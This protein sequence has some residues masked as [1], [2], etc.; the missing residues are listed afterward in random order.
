MIDEAWVATLIAKYPHVREVYLCGS[1]AGGWARPTSDWDVLLVL[2]DAC[3]D[4]G[5][6]LDKIEQ[7]IAFDPD[8]RFDGLD[9]FFWR[10]PWGELAR[11]EF[12][13]DEDIS[14]RWWV[15]DPVFEPYYRTGGIPGD[16]DRFY[17]DLRFARRLH[18]P[19]RRR[20]RCGSAPGHDST[21]Q[22]PGGHPTL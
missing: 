2:D 7:R 5:R 11:W 20:R 15:G 18:P 22:H 17:K 19:R 16:W 8:L 10:P 21:R 4:G 12:G 6:P 13:P 14:D 1:R 9:L 3:Y